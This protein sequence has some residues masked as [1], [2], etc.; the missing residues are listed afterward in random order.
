MAT[1]QE[2]YDFI[3]NK[4]AVT[5]EGN[6]FFSM[7]IETTRGRTHKVYAGV[8]GNALQLTAPVV[9][10]NRID[11]DG[12]LSANTSMFGIVTAGGAYSLKHNVFV[13]DI[14]ESEIRNAF[15]KLAVEADD[16]EAQLGFQDEF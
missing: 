5:D 4:Y 15:L 12:V 7:E 16:L 11:A 6:R 13:E 3:F 14:D 8:Q 2:V 9:W 10:A 1:E